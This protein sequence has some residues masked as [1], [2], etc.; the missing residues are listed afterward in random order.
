[1]AQR[2][3]AAIAASKKKEDD[4]YDPI[5]TVANFMSGQKWPFDREEH[6]IFGRLRGINGVYCIAYVWYLEQAVLGYT[7]AFE[8]CSRKK[9]AT[10]KL[11]LII[12]ECL[13]LGH[14]EYRPEMKAVVHRSSH[15]VPNGELSPLQAH[16]LL[17]NGLTACDSYHIAFQ[18]V[19]MG[20][21]PAEAFELGTKFA[22]TEGTA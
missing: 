19:A 17:I 4:T 9:S 16:A 6:A 18:M 5:E 20:K 1:M 12:N 7:C 2:T 21:S 11:A 10:E 14:F 22:H 8:Y 15:V 13:P 3:F